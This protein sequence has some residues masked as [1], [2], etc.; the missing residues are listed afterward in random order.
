MANEKLEALIIVETGGWKLLLTDND[1]A[2]VSIFIPAGYYYLTSA[3]T[4]HG[5]SVSFLAAVKT[6]LDNG[7]GVT[8]TVTLDDDTD[9]ATGKITIAVSAGTFAIVWDGTS[10]TSTAPRDLLGFA[11]N[12]AATASSQGTKQAKRLW[13][14]LSNH[15]SDEPNPAAV[16]DPFGTEETDYIAAIAP[17]GAP[18]MT[19]L[20]IRQVSRRFRYEPVLGYKRFK[21]L[22]TIANES[23]QTFLRDMMGDTA[24][25]A[26][27]PFRIYADRSSDA[28]YWTVFFDVEEGS[29][30]AA[31]VP[32]VEGWRG[33]LAHWAVEF[34]ARQYVNA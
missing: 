24:G 14:P 30:P 25:G 26:G 32:L 9:L 20:N 2:G 27:V 16:G 6:A 13:L 34:T 31:A 3:A 28:L 22:E 12:I 7:A 10:S 11:G 17:S 5:G 4:E 8:Y 15:L 21:S 18:A 33:A 29:D 23:W 19:V 1:G